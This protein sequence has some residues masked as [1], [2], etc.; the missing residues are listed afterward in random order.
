MCCVKCVSGWLRG[1]GGE[2][3]G[4]NGGASPV[5]DVDLKV[6]RLSAARERR[7]QGDQQRITGSI[8]VTTPKNRPF[9]AQSPSRLTRQTAA[10][11]RLGG[12]TAPGRQSRRELLERETQVCQ[13]VTGRDSEA[14]N[15][16][17]SRR[18]TTNLISLFAGSPKRWCETTFRFTDG[19]G[20]TL[21]PPTTSQFY[22][23]Y[24]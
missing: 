8:H 19:D 2:R 23:T 24:S 3:R 16:D 4:W 20:Q 13:T 11:E 6:T 10:V 15:V 17:G 22:R 12:G 9:L 18:T 1:C 7:R 14:R 21:H 5:C